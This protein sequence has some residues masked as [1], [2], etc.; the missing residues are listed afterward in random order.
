MFLFGLS[1]VCDI[2]A[3]TLATPCQL[4]SPHLALVLPLLAKLRLRG[5]HHQRLL[6]HDFCGSSS[7]PPTPSSRPDPCFSPS[8]CAR[9][10]YKR[11]PTL[12]SLPTICFLLHHIVYPRK[13]DFANTVTWEHKGTTPKR[14]HRLPAFSKRNVDSINSGGT[15]P[16]LSTTGTSQLY[17]ISVCPHCLQPHIGII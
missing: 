17:D 14:Y 2:S 16:G 13:L 11:R 6:S 1:T 7:S 8:S 4:P 15:N 5:R 12:D 3:S 9:H 10:F